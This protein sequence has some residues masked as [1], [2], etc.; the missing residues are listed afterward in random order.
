MN[1]EKYLKFL[2]EYSPVIKEIEIEAARIHDE[3]NQ[4]YDGW[5]Y[6]IHLREVARIVKHFGYQVIQEESQ[7]LQLIFGA[8]FHDSIEDARLTYNDV[9]KISAKFGLVT[10]LPADIVYSLTNLRG[11]NRASRASF[12]YYQGIRETQFASLIKLADR[13]ANMWYSKSTGS[14]MFLVYKK[15]WKHFIN[16]I[17]SPEVK[18]PEDLI[19]L[20]ENLMKDYGTK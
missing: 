20:L 13:A 19:C 17:V 9:R 3:V 6:I 11:K 7:I 12:E 18:L 16:S 5:P 4:E 8:Y 2:D 1:K 10:T 14:R 15:E